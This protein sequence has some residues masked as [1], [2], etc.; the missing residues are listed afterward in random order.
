ML[1]IE[2]SAIR[3]KPEP[4]FQEAKQ[5][6]DLSKADV[7]VAVGRGIKS[8]DNL[9]LAEKLAEALG[10]DLPQRAPEQ[11]CPLPA[12][13]VFAREIEASGFIKRLYEK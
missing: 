6:V 3:Q 9:A 2:A 1:T 10:G 8:K 13:D 7:I 11:L 4:P 5:A 12:M